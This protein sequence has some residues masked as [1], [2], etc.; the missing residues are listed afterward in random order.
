VVFSTLRCAAN[1]LFLFFFETFWTL[2][3]ECST[4]RVT[5]PD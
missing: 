5:L 1:F 4:L 2:T 3:N